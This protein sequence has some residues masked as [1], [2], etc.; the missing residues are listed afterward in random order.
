MWEAVLAQLHQ[1]GRW[2]LE[3]RGH[4]PEL[5]A[6][7]SLT[8]LFSVGHLWRLKI[9]RFSRGCVSYLV[10]SYKALSAQSWC[11]VCHLVW[12]LHSAIPL[13]AE[14]DPTSFS[15]QDCEGET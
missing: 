13:T 9:L 14:T 5:S 2:H 10:L 6:A 11:V 12:I 4:L 7:N 1:E 8:L 3:S 15:I